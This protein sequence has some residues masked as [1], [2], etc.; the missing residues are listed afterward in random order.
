MRGALTH[1]CGFPAT[2]AKPEWTAPLNA[3]SFSHRIKS[4]FDLQTPQHLAPLLSAEL[5]PSLSL[6]I[7]PL[8]V[9]VFGHS[10]LAGVA[11]HKVRSIAACIYRF[12]CFLYLFKTRTHFLHQIMQLVYAAR[13]YLGCHR[14]FCN[15]PS[16]WSLSSCGPIEP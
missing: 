1:I 7:T 16:L 13:P 3:S 10:H 5:C 4:D 6:D 12:D 15:C 14:S 11:W 2:C 9:V 8:S